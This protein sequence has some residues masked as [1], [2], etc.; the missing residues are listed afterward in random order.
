MLLVPRGRWKKYGRHIHSF[1]F[2]FSLFC[3]CRRC[4]VQLQWEPEYKVGKG[5]GDPHLSVRRRRR[6]TLRRR[7][8]WSAATVTTTTHLFLQSVS[9]Q[10]QWR[11]G[12]QRRQSSMMHGMTDYAASVCERG[13]ESRF[14]RDSRRFA[15]VACQSSFSV[16]VH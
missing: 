5:R 8:R 12:R 13:K 11:N 4:S 16:G 3:L 9:Q 10:R 15:V 1:P 2:L 6:R 14:E 7:R